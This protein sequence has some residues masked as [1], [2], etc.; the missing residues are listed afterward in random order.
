MIGYL[1]IAATSI[2]NVRFADAFE[3]RYNQLER[4]SVAHEGVSAVPEKTESNDLVGVLC[5]SETATH[6]PSS[7]SA[8][9]LV[10]LDVLLRLHRGP[11]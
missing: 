6:L 3:Q 1:K 8:K 4:G 2:G 7:N 5:R 10:L 9:R 11:Q